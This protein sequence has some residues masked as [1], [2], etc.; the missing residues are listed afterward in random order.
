MSTIAQSSRDAAHLIRAGA[1]SEGYKAII[2]HRATRVNPRTGKYGGYHSGTNEGLRPGSDYS[3]TKPRDKVGLSKASAAMDIG[4]RGIKG[5][6]GSAARAWRAQR[7]FTVWL[8]AEVK[9]GRA[10]LMEIVGP[11]ANG[12]ATYWSKPDWVPSKGRDRLHPHVGY[13][14][15]TE[16]ADRASQFRGFFPALA[17]RRTFPPTP[18]DPEPDDDDVPGDGPTQDEFDTAIER[19]EQAEAERDELAVLLTACNQRGS[20]RAAAIR[21]LEAR[22]AAKDAKAQELVTL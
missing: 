5:V 16:F 7:D 2:S 15:D 4:F 22:I 11:N 19:A 13:P 18:D 9:A 3:T 21:T 12:I 10:D 17:E 14:R 20:E 8:V 6:A 1:A